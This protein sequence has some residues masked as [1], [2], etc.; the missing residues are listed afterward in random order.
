MRKLEVEDG[1]MMRIAIQNEIFRSEE[2]RYDHRLHGV[3]LVAQGLTCR[4]VSEYLGQNPVTVQRW[5]R[6]FNSRGF[7]ALQE[8]ERPGRPSRIGEL[9]WSQ[10]EVDLRQ[11]P[12]DLGYGQ[13]LWDG[14]LLSH[15]LSA[16]YGV[17]LA[18]R[19]CQRIFRQMGFRLRKPRPLIA[20]GDREAQRR[21][22]K[23]ASSRSRRKR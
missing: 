18:V 21:Y 15:H 1:Q 16:H 6:G 9:Q 7:A 14:K 11:A 23:T 22:K 19:Q 10:M 8:G 4:K 17:D 3:L 5:V 12:R 20:G 13:N 2:S